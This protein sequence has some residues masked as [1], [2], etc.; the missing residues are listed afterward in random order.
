MC[1]TL[2]YKEALQHCAMSCMF[3]LLSYLE[4][5][6]INTTLGLWIVLYISHVERQL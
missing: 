5:K 1:G 2:Y 3:G 4:S 6:G